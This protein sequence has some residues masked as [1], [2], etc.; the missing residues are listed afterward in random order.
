MHF[1]NIHPDDL[2]L[3][4]YQ[5]ETTELTPTYRCDLRTQPP[6]LFVDESAT[7]WSKCFWKDVGKPYRI[8]NYSNRRKEWER[9]HQKP[10]PA[11]IQWRF[12][13]RNMHELANTNLVEKL[14]AIKQRLGRQLRYLKIKQADESMKELSRLKLWNHLHQQEDAF[15]DPRGKRALF[16]GLDVKKPKILVLGA[17]DGYDG[18]LLSAMYPGGH[19]VLVDFDDFC[20]TDRFGNFPEEY[21]FLARDPKT[22]YWNVYVKPELNIDFVVSDIQDLHYG[23]EF[24]IVVSTGLLEHYP[25]KY[26]PLVFH[27]HRQFLKPGGYII[28]TTTRSQMR[29]RTFYRL[30]RDLTNYTYREL[31]NVHQLGLY[32]YEN[33]LKVLRCG[34]IKAH[35][36][37]ISR[38]R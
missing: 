14:N 5:L 4:A 12:Y 3:V 2:H 29:T 11:R 28:M 16:E 38:E 19:T 32:A 23:R 31:M 30:M 7:D 17:G 27:F 1:E 22:G 24:D 20:R 10:M 36:S 9:A 33:G 25:D 6:D 37:I 26:K 8:E 34:Y 15:W 21:P 18:M 35:N 13:N